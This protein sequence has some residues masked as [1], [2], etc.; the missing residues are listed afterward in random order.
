[1]NGQELMVRESSQVGQVAQADNDGQVIAMWLHG[2]P[3][4]TQRA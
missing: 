1:M 4:T 2:R 3:H